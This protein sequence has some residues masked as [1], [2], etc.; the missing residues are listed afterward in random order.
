MHKLLGFNRLCIE[1]HSASRRTEATAILG[2]VR[3]ARRLGF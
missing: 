3:W 1:C 2:F